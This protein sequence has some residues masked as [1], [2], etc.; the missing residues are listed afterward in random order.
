MQLRPFSMVEM[1]RTAVVTTML[2][3]LFGR[4]AANTVRVSMCKRAR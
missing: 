2:K 1:L 3:I 4:Q